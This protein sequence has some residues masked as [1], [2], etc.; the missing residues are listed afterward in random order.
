MKSVVLAI[1]FTALADCCAA[2]FIGQKLAQKA[3]KSA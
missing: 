3:N 1:A 2:A